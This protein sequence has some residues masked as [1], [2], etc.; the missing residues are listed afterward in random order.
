MKNARREA[1]IY[2]TDG[3]IRASA[4]AQVMHKEYG[5]LICDDEGGTLFIPW[6]QV[7]RIETRRIP[8]WESEATVAQ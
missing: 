5:V 7:Q 1:R 8:A 3:E 2:T 4:P 6:V